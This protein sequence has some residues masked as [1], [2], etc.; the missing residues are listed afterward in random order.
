MEPND[1]NGVDLPSQLKFLPFYELQTKL[2][3]IPNLDDFN[4]EEDHIRAVNSNYY[5][6]RDLIR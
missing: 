4:I 5:D 6:L 3:H 1:F 2:S